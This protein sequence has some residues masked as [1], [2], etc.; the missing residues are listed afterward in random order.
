MPTRTAYE[1]GTFCWIDV[2]T[3]DPDG[4]AAFYR[5]VFGWTVED[6]RAGAGYHLFAHHGQTVAGLDPLTEADVAAGGMAGWNTYV[7]VADAAA[8]AERAAQLGATIIDA[9]HE[10]AD[11][12][13]AACLAD[14]GGAPLWLWQPSTFAGAAVVNEPG[15]W[16]WNDLQTLD[17]DGAAAFYRELLGWEIGPAP[18][19]S[20]YRTI[21]NN[22]RMIGGLMPVPAGAPQQSSWTVYFGVHSVGAT[23][24]HVE[25]ADGTRLVDPMDIEGGRFAVAQDPFGAVFSLFEGQFDD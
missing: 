12:G 7:T 13:M 9:P 21:I 2:D 8:T 18:G 24:E 11:A 19:G 15:A 16:T 14:P 20:P 4:A 17:V 22:G 1:P 25:A 5:R 3:P 23:L 10:V 6:E